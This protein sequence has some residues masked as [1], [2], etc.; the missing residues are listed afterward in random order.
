MVLIMPLVGGAIGVH[1]LEL[2][3]C[4]DICYGMFY[5]FFSLNHQGYRVLFLMY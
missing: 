1:F 5:V 3:D 2:E 4:C